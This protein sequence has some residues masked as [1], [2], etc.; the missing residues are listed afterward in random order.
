MNRILGKLLYLITILI[1]SKQSILFKNVLKEKYENYNSTIRGLISNNLINCLII[2]EDRRFYQHFG[3]DFKA[4]SKAILQNIF[5]NFKRGASTIEQQIVRTITKR[6]E[7]TY[8]RKVREILLAPL[9]D[10]MITKNDITGFYLFIAYYGYQMEGIKNACFKLNLNFENI[11]MEN[12]ARLIA[13]IKYPE[14]K[15]PTI[16]RINQ[17]NSRYNKILDDYKKYNMNSSNSL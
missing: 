15:L 6:Y 17:I 14:T 10:K 8:R 13:R 3:I 1:F 5:N 4:I 16:K 7:I 11:T 2:A 9:V 12:S